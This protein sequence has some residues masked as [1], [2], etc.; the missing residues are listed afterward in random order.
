LRVLSLSTL[1]PNPA[2]PGLG[3]FVARSLEAAAQHGDVDLTVVNPI[4]LPPWPLSRHS[5]YAGLADLPAVASEGGLTVLRPRF[6]LYPKVGAAS[7]P[8]RICDAVLPLVRR[9]HAESRFDLIDAQFFFPDGPAAARIASELGLPFSIKARGADI[10]HWGTQPRTGP[11]VLAAARQATGL[12]AVCEALKA[13]MVE[14]GVPGDKI[15]VHYTGLD[16]E[17][18]RPIERR[19]ARDMVAQKFGLPTEAPLL[20]TTGALIPR[21]GQADAIKSLPQ[22]PGAIL[23]LAGRGESEGHLRRLAAELGVS[24]RVHFL[25]QVGHEDLPA[26]LAAADAMVLL[27]ASEGLANAWIEAL[28]C[29]T[30][31]VITDSGGAREVVRDP[32][33]GRVVIRGPES[34]STAVRELFENPPAQAAV[35]KNAAGFNWVA[36]GA[37]LVAYWS[38]LIR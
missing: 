1:Y 5:R 7:N 18:F 32:S 8:R 25:G 16:H 4:G 19:A 36:N 21:K 20:V 33:A 38:T 23:A 3:Q 24:D 28:A 37:E 11:Q 26:L 22:L 6:R 35:A 12:L 29:G 17:R 2:R 34:V 9:L 30:P 31:I 15:V 10:H 27:S 13:D 14:L